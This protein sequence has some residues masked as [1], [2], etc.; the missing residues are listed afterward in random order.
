MRKKGERYEN[1][2]KEKDIDNSHI[3]DSAFRMCYNNNHIDT[4]KNFLD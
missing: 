3:A 2:H 1:R 4:G